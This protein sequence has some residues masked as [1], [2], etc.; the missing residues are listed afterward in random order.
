MNTARLIESTLSMRAVDSIVDRI[1]Q[2]KSCELY[3]TRPDFRTLVDMYAII[4]GALLSPVLGWNQSQ[5]YPKA[6]IP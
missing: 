2:L 3:E 5:A 4:Y 1:S 6:W